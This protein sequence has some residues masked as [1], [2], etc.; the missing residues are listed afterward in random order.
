MKE[1]LI[2]G[3]LLGGCFWFSYWIEKSH[4]LLIDK[5]D[6]FEELLGGTLSARFSRL[7][8]KIDAIRL[9]KTE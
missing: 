9:G 8:E 3:L 1:W 5:I 7:E 4:K 6:R 2:L